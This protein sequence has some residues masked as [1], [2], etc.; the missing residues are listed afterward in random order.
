MRSSVA[1]PIGCTSATELECGSWI[2]RTMR[3]RADLQVGGEHAQVVAVARP[4]HHA[5]QA[6]A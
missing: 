5:V 6:E 3:L 2:M 1:S 4:E